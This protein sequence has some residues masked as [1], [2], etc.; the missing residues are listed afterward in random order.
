MDKKDRIVQQMRMRPHQEQLRDLMDAYFFNKKVTD[1]LR[2]ALTGIQEVYAHLP[3]PTNNI[4]QLAKAITK[5]SVERQK[6]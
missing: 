6:Q 5:G 4:H 1:A 3:R 2:T